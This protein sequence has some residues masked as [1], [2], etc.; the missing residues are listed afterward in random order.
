MSGNVVRCAWK[1]LAGLIVFVVAT[2]LFGTEAEAE[3][4][5]KQAGDHR[6]YYN[7]GRAV[8][9]LPVERTLESTQPSVP[10]YSNVPKP[11]PPDPLEPYGCPDH[12][13]PQNAL[14][15][16][17]Q[18]GLTT[19]EELGV[20]PGLPV[21]ADKIGLYPARQDWQPP[22]LQKDIFN[23]WCN[24]ADIKETIPG[25]L[26]ACRRKRSDPSRPWPDWAAAYGSIDGS[27][28]A[29]LGDAFTAFCQAD[30]FTYRIGRCYVAY[31]LTKNIGISYEFHP[32]GTE[33][34]MSVVP[35]SDLIEFDQRLR[36]Y[37][38]DHL[39]PGYPW[40]K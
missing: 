23:K 6:T 18:S 1:A 20:K 26:I 35:L 31:L 40:P 10:L 19:G 5:C 30:L 11:T 32:Y 34:V 2:A 29:P 37:V 25:G 7:I 14:G 22:K 36:R 17:F 38:F 27:Y 24:E 33:A 28:R 12:P 3:I 13:S 21:R 4:K 8:F 9:A 15:V 39:V 16:S